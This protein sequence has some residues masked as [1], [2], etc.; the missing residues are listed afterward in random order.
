MYAP[1]NEQIRPL[2][3]LVWNRTPFYSSKYQWLLKPADFL[4]SFGAELW[5]N[6][7]VPN[8]TSA[9]ALSIL[10]VRVFPSPSP[11]RTTTGSRQLP[12]VNLGDCLRPPTPTP[13]PTRFVH[14]LHGGR[15]RRRFRSTGSGWL[16]KNTPLLGRFWATSGCSGSPPPTERRQGNHPNARQARL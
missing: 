3:P 13:T 7:I 2:T 15:A 12:I 16:R 6:P 5:R 4:W 9:V 1:L 14:A 8:A 10:V 11:F